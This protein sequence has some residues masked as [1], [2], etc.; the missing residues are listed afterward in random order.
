MLEIGQMHV[1]G[2][3]AIAILLG[4]FIGLERECADKPAGLRT[5]MLVAGT[6]ALL[7]NLNGVLVGAFN[8]SA[9]VN[10]TAD[11]VRIVQAIVMGIGFLGAGTIIQRRSSERIEGLTTGA[12]L[13]LAASLGVCVAAGQ[14]VLA[15]GV[16][17][18]ALCV[19]LLLGLL[20]KWL[21]R[22]R[23]EPRQC[24]ESTAGHGEG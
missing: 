8:V 10:I 18:L 22:R 23:R 21:A 16:T 15:A 2:E 13:L 6:S 24:G 12:S 3:V 9:N 19:L 4:G 1:L 7:V 5:H 14:L 20:E 11:P 17:A